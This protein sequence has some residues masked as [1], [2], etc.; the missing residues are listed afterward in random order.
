V[1]STAAGVPVRVLDLAL[2]EAGV[3]RAV[4]KVSLVGD[5]PTEQ[6]A[7]KYSVCDLRADGGPD[8]IEAAV[9]A[10]CGRNLRGFVVLGD[11]AFQAL[12]ARTQNLRDAG[13][14]AWEKATREGLTANASA[15]VALAD[16]T[17]CVD[18]LAYYVEEVRG[19][20]ANLERRFQLAAEC[21]DDD[22]PLAVNL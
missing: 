10:A 1:I 6:H 15:V 8:E 22:S 9:V 3:A 2:A 18:Q 20:L 4:V 14:A 19:R 7:F 5:P 11:A 17:A 12:R 13:R 21:R 16:L